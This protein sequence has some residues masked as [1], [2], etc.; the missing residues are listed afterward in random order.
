VPV[1]RKVNG[2]AKHA[3]H[4]N[5]YGRLG[6]ALSKRTI[7][8]LAVLHAMGINSL[9]NVPKI[10]WCKASPGDQ[11]HLQFAAGHVLPYTL[12]CA[13]TLQWQGRFRPQKDVRHHR[14]SVR[15]LVECGTTVLK[16]RFSRA[17]ANEFAPGAPPTSLHRRSGPPQSAGSNVDRCSHNRSRGS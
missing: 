1:I 11:T 16:R 6:Y 13:L 5:E 12:C 14:G 17:D 10:C 2:T 3:E 9:E 8:T 15:A 4:A 7:A